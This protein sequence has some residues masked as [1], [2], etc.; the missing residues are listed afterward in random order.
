MEL[1]LI[2]ADASFMDVL[3]K[4]YAFVVAGSALVASFLAWRK[5]QMALNAAN[6]ARF[7]AGKAVTQAQVARDVAVEAKSSAERMEQKI[8]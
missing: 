5:G 1:A 8:P 2:F 7:E 6:Q 4:L 3:E